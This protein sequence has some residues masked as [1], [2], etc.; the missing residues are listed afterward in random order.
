MTSHITCEAARGPTTPHTLHA[1]SYHSN[2][3]RGRR[4]I[5]ACGWPSRLE[6]ARETS[7]LATMALTPGVLSRAILWSDIKILG[8]AAKCLRSDSAPHI[9]PDGGKTGSASAGDY[10][11]CPLP[12]LFR[13]LCS[14]IP[15]G[16]GVG[17]PMR[18]GVPRR[19]V[20]V[21]APR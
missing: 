5:T 15:V 19:Y 16:C 8:P 18:A 6:G 7:L 13:R 20:V 14:I 12:V 21:L 11:V 2:Q 9:A 17:L 3:L 10:F 1:R 4:S